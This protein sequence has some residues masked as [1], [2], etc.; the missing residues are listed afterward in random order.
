LT[1]SYIDHNAIHEAGHVIIALCCELDVKEVLIKP[2][3]KYAA[4]CE[5][6]PTQAIPRAV[7]A[8]KLAGSIAV[9]I[10][11]AKETKTDDDGF[12]TVQDEESD[13]YCIA[14][15]ELYWSALGMTESDVADCRSKLQ[16]FVNSALL[17]YWPMVEAL[18]QK[19]ATLTPPGPPVTARQI[20]E[21]IQTVEPAFHEKV[22]A[23][24]L[25]G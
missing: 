17:R 24:L 1:M 12:G 4:R 18:A 8:M 25:T 23:H 19:I 10:Q 5:F 7:Y 9:D 22:K 2:A 13:A 3:G 11:N 14:C 16:S 20:G 21:I 6:I 15:L